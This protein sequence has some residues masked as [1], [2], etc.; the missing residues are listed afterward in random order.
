MGGRVDVGDGSVG[1]AL[2][3]ADANDRPVALA[4]DVE[5]P[6]TE[7]LDLLAFGEFTDA[8]QDDAYGVGMGYRIRPDSTVFASVTDGEE[9]RAMHL[10]L[11]YSF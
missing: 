8:G 2:L 7:T 3:R 9:G 5:M 6:V 11:E 1:A 10:S 4:L